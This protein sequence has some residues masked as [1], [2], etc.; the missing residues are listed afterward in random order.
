MPYL[1]ENTTLQTLSGLGWTNQIPA[2]KAIAHFTIRSDERRKSTTLN[3]DNGLGYHGYLFG[4]RPYFS[5]VKLW[6]WGHAL[7]TSSSSTASYSLIWFQ[8]A[9]I[10]S[11]T[12]TGVYVEEVGNDAEAQCA[13]GDNE[14]LKLEDNDAGTYVKIRIGS[15]LTVD[16]VIKK[17]EVRP[18]RWVGPALATIEGSEWTGTGVVET[19]KS[20]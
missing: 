17:Q 12:F 6:Q 2:A 5:A 10:A 11:K 14:L 8:A 7:V 16:L 13:D 3:F 15:D 19:L 4:D 1:S 18:G 9:D 20:Q